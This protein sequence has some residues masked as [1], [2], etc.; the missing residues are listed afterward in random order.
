MRRSAATQVMCAS[1]FVSFLAAAGSEGSMAW[2][3]G[4]LDALAE[5]VH[6]LPVLPEVP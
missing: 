6:A 5:G 3:G 4:S 1:A 2:P